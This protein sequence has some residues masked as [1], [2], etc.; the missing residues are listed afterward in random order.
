MVQQDV[1][2]AWDFSTGL[3]FVSNPFRVSMVVECIAQVSV[4]FIKIEGVIITRICTFFHKKALVVYRSCTGTF[5][6]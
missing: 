4:E 5:T 2:S 3:N 1:T 6:H